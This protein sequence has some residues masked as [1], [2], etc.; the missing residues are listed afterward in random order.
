[1][2]IPRNNAIFRYHL[3]ATPTAPSAVG[4]G[5]G[6]G[7]AA[8][9]A[10]RRIA[11]ALSIGIGKSTGTLGKVVKLAGS[12]TGIGTPAATLKISRGLYGAG[13]GI[14]KSTNSNI[15]SFKRLFGPTTGIGTT[16]ITGLVKRYALVPL[17]VPTGIGYSTGVIGVNGVALT[18]A[19]AWGT[20]PVFAPNGFTI[21][22]DPS[23]YHPAVVHTYK[24][25]LAYDGGTGVKS[26]LFN[27]TANAGVA[28]SEVT[29]SGVGEAADYESDAIPI[30]SFGSGTNEYRAEVAKILG[31]E[32]GRV[33]SAKLV[34][35]SS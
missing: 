27:M 34:H 30:A 18:W 35:R 13:I 29:T 20:T 17:V 22:F 14:G 26:R 32:Y 24:A 10:G 5:I 6:S 28:G 12:A 4:V 1:V 11:G 33:Y 7:A 25:R 31:I 23:W 21:E 9:S 3:I 19:P 8:L 16:T 2:G 15:M